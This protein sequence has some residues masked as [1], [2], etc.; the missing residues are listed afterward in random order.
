MV[1][2]VFFK[3]NTFVKSNIRQ[4]FS[5]NDLKIIIK[6]D[7]TNYF[8]STI[9]NIPSDFS[10]DCKFL[11]NDVRLQK[12]IKLYSLAIY[13]IYDCIPINYCTYVHLT[14]CKTLHWQTQKTMI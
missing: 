5:M 14:I 2:N 13:Q 10:M 12:E 11:C 9:N 7:T 1:T 8:D 6:D 4:L 3:I